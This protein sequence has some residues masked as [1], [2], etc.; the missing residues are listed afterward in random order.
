MSDGLCRHCVRG[1]QWLLPPSHSTTTVTQLT[2]HGNHRCV[3]VGSTHVGAS[4]WSSGSPETYDVQYYF[5]SIWAFGVISTRATVSVPTSRK[6]PSPDWDAYQFAPPYIS[7][8]FAGCTAW[9]RPNEN[10]E[11]GHYLFSTIPWAYNTCVFAVARERNYSTCCEF[12]PTNSK[13]VLNYDKSRTLDCTN[14]RGGLPGLCLRTDRPL[15]ILHGEHMCCSTFHI[16]C[17]C[18]QRFFMDS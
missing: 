2:A 12:L 13:F 6:I 16:C 1:H 7:L 10:P 5:P 17:D 8:P 4:S 18:S 14:P 11:T 3:Q 9:P 15:S